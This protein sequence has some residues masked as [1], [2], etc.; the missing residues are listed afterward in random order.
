VVNCC[1]V[2][3]PGTPCQERARSPS[4]TIALYESEPSG[5]LAHD[6]YMQR[7]HMPYVSMEGLPDPYDS[8]QYNP[9]EDTHVQQDTMDYF[10]PYDVFAQYTSTEAEALR[11][12]QLFARRRQLLD[13]WSSFFNKDI[14]RL[15]PGR[16]RFDEYR[17]I[18][19]HILAP[20]TENIW[21]TS[22]NSLLFLANSTIQDLYTLRKVLEHWISIGCHID[23]QNIGGL[24]PLLYFCT[25]SSMGL[26]YL[27]LLLAKRANVDAVDFQGR[28]AL[29]LVMQSF[30]GGRHARHSLKRK[31]D[32]IKEEKVDVFRW[33][34]K[35]ENKLS[36]LLH[37]GCKPALRDNAGRTPD[38]Y[39]EVG[40]DCWEVWRSAL[41]K[42]KQQKDLLTLCAEAIS[43]P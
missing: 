14:S 34:T 40:S 26:Q 36:I 33:F 9:V 1:T 38:E 12:N 39:V 3:E 6:E 2:S 13:L 32:R 29:H 35:V 41:S 4:A 28:G 5:A 31:Q 19:N 42:R 22:N 27:S 30:V 10:N 24:T 20:C 11:D 15:Q 17:K 37:A 23:H 7:D 8:M 16:D 21:H 18:S 25:N 43:A